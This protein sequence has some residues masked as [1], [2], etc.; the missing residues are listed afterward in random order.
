MPTSMPDIA[1]HT[2]AQTEGRLDWV[3][4]GDIEMPIMI[5]SQRPITAYG[6]CLY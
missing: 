2:K 6:F 1:N 3:G 5:A 4:M